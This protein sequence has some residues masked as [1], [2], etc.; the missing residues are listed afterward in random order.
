LLAAPL[1]AQSNKGAV[2]IED[3]TAFEASM[4]LAGKKPGKKQISI[5]AGELFTFGEAMITAKTDWSFT[6]RT[7]GLIRLLRVDTGPEVIFVPEK[8]VKVFDVEISDPDRR[9]FDSS[10]RWKSSFVEAA[11]AAWMG[12]ASEKTGTQQVASTASATAGGSGTQQAASKATTFADITGGPGVYLLSSQTVWKDGTNY[13]LKDGNP[14]FNAMTVSGEDLY[15][16]GTTEGESY[17]RATLWKNGAAQQLDMV[18]SNARAVFVSGND[19]Y[20]AG[21]IGADDGMRPV[22]WK[23]G[24]RQV[25]GEARGKDSWIPRRVSVSGGIVTVAGSQR[26]YD[27]WKNESIT[28]WKNGKEQ[29]V[30]PTIQKIVKTDKNGR[31]SEDTPSLYSWHDGSSFFESNGDVYLAGNVISYLIEGRFETRYWKNGQQQPLNIGNADKP[32]IYVSGKDVYIYSIRNAYD[33]KSVSTLWKN[34]VK[35]KLESFENPETLAEIKTSIRNVFAAGN[36]VYVFGIRDS[37]SAGGKQHGWT[38]MLWKNGKAEVI[39]GAS[40]PFAMFVA[41]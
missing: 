25:L 5:K 39:T 27:Q 17:R 15:V 31:K 9:P 40:Q 10:Y 14:D 4:L 21:T 28:T 3:C 12:V 16:V 32:R 24:E 37:Y 26:E 41:Q 11:K 8:S 29:T 22:L 38:Y 2:A 6:I 19:V 35:Q 1:F 7:D 30:V 13:P 18:A 33:D 36:D 34:G 23:N 20:V